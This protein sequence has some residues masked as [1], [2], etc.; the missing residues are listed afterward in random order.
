MASNEVLATAVLALFPADFDVHTQVP[1]GAEVPWV[2]VSMTLP[3]V[4][5]RSL[6]R[7]PHL[8]RCVVR[9]RLVAA[10]DTAVRQM[11]DIVLPALE[12]H[13]PVATGWK[14]TGLAQLG[15]QRVDEDYDVTLTPTAAH[16]MVGYSD[17]DFTATPA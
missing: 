9:V 8:S 17:W 4:I 13:R 7:T 1:S 12:G 15:E 10:N 11:A 16:P 6:G 2:F 5:E 3:T 14:T